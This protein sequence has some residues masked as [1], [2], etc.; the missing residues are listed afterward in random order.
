MRVDIE[1]VHTTVAILSSYFT[2]SLC[3]CSGLFMAP[4]ERNFRRGQS[5]PRKCLLSL[6]KGR[7]W[8]ALWALPRTQRTCRRHMWWGE[9]NVCEST[10]GRK[11]HT[12]KFQKRKR[13][14]IHQMLG[15][16]FRLYIHFFH[17][18]VPALEPQRPRVDF[19]LRVFAFVDHQQ[20][21]RLVH[22]DRWVNVGA[23]E[24]YFWHLV[25][26]IGVL[27]CRKKCKRAYK[28]EVQNA[29]IKRRDTRSGMGQRRVAHIFSC[30][31]GESIEE[32]YYSALPSYYLF[33]RSPACTRTMYV[34][35]T[36]VQYHYMY[37]H[38]LPPRIYV[39][40]SR[41]TAAASSLNWRL[42]GWL[43]WDTTRGTP[44]SP[45]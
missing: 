20:V 18:C 44:E 41:A 22:A 15:Q 10:D 27:Y 9:G 13:R 17:V 23:D 33:T 7:E 31:Q 32:W 30:I 42:V 29:K 34:T 37:T 35:H 12:I 43:G 45:A 19:F 1:C 36:L 39:R 21:R 28:S 8:G 2:L 14:A 16:G 40:T 4:E 25:A 38:T 26:L 5:P 24:P 6:R 11:V 3:N